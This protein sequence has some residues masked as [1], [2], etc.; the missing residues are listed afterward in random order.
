MA[1]ITVV[2]QIVASSL[3]APNCLYRIDDGTGNIEARQWIDLT[4][5]GIGTSG[6]IIEM[7]NSEGAYVRITG[8]LKEIGSKRYIHISHARVSNDVHELYF[9]ILEAISVHLYLER[10]L[11]SLLMLYFIDSVSESYYSLIQEGYIFTTID[12]FHFKCTS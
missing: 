12:D 1:Q 2:A 4:L 11:V 5:E 9:H 7:N 3:Q 8:T 10:G 6:D